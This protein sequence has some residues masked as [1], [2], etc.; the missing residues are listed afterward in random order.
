MTAIEERLEVLSRLPGDVVS[1][2]SPDGEV[3]YVSPAI[4]RT[5]GYP[6]DI[7]TSLDMGALVHPDDRPAA[8]HAWTNLLARAGTSDRWELR[9]RHA[10]GQWRWIEVIA[11]NN[12]D[13]PAI[14]AIVTNFRDVTERRQAED[15]LRASEARLRTVLQNS[16]DVTAVLAEDGELV[17]VSP[18]IVA[19]LGWPDDTV[20]GMNAFDLVHPED[21]PA[22]LDQFV[23][24]I[25]N[26]EAVDPVVLRLRRH[27]GGWVLAEVAGTVWR[28]EG[29]GRGGR[30]QRTRHQ[31]ASRSR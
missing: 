16:R 22:A 11:H 2:L 10:D 28:N 4:E 23:T 29:R 7:Y 19:M 25:G 15:A 30:G 1:L 8:D 3:G 31:L 27:D 6:V 12:L 14:G 9:M 5:L 18:G 20:T 21:V 13:D 26:E 24:A 17:W